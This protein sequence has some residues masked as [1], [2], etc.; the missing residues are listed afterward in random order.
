MI[1]DSTSPLD[2]IFTATVQDPEKF[3]DDTESYTSESSH[4]SS[5]I[6]KDST[7]K[8]TK[9]KR[10]RKPK[11]P[12]AQSGI[13]SDT[14][15]MPSKST[16][17]GTKISSVTPSSEVTVP[18]LSSSKTV[19]KKEK[20]TTRDS[21]ST[22]SETDANSVDRKKNKFQPRVVL[23]EISDKST[24]STTPLSRNKPST[25][26]DDTD[27]DRVSYKVK[28]DQCGELF[29]NERK[30]TVHSSIH[31]RKLQCFM[32]ISQ[33]DARDDLV[34]HLKDIHQRPYVCYIEQCTHACQTTNG[35]KQHMASKHSVRPSYP[36]P[37]CPRKLKTQQARDRHAEKC[38][39][40]DLPE[41]CFHCFLKFADRE[42]LRGHLAGEHRITEI[43][44][45]NCH[46]E[47]QNPEELDAH[48]AE[49][50]CG[51]IVDN[52]EKSLSQK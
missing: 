47:F 21:K 43:V 3:D 14:K 18:K 7:S 36:C 29:D 32:C 30:L 6:K 24:K 39:Q 2:D 44:C 20:V 16:G 52:R 26:T 38:N 48:T 17:K 35:L 34:T 49:D 13:A 22:E 19:I 12:G 45:P 1:G 27:K 11:V 46:S 28:C 31:T 15:V 40:K 51:D 10:A 5:I 8:S 33:F 41:T 23:K 25:S 9:A 4:H 50:V 42:T 37:S